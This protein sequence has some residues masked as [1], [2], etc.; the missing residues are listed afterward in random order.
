M[1]DTAQARYFEFEVSPLDCERAL[2]CTTLL[3]RRLIV[4]S[5]KLVVVTNR[6]LLLV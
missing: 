1:R 5:L 4:Y 3:R 2:L 6:S